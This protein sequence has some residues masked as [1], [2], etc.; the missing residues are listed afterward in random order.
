[1]TGEES[2]DGLAALLGWG[3]GGIST[4]EDYY[5]SNEHP[6]SG[7]VGRSDHRIEGQ[8]STL[9]RNGIRREGAVWIARL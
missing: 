7:K 4:S 5:N 2:G 3:G 6:R 1:M 8:E 9:I